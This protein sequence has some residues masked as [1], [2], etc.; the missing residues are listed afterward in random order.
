MIHN[1]K[2][3]VKFPFK[4]NGKNSHY[5]NKEFLGLFILIFNG[6]LMHWEL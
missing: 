6:N 4:E 3:F 2:N 1:K 5:N